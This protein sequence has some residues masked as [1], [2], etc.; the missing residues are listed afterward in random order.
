MNASTS[1]DASWLWAWFVRS[2][3]R[4]EQPNYMQIWNEFHQ[5][6]VLFFE[7]DAEDIEDSIGNLSLY[8]DPTQ[9]TADPTP[10]RRYAN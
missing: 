7:A 6:L 1:I 10:P 4:G 9:P 3:A 8:T 5:V 2:Q